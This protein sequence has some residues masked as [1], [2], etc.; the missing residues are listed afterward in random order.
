M[1]RLRAWRPCPLRCAVPASVSGVC[2]RLGFAPPWVSAPCLACSGTCRPVV[3]PLKR[4]ARGYSCCCACGARAVC[5]C[6]LG[7]SPSCVP[8]LRECGQRQH[9]TLAV[10]RQF[11][12]VTRC[13]G[14]DAGMQPISP[15]DG[16]TCAVP[17][18]IVPR[19]P[20]VPSPSLGPQNRASQIGR[21]SVYLG[22]CR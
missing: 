5:S 10:V 20:V 1:N 9:A 12:S 14:S 19:Q 17:G 11:R 15:T 3:K 8:W 21:K 4:A 7:C 6:A 2:L 22:V 16:V 13:N 18:E